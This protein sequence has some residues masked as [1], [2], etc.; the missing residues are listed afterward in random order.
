MADDKEVI[1]VADDCSTALTSNRQSLNADAAGVAAS[2]GQQV[3]SAHACILP[4]A[5]T[6]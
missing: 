4:M 6:R 2:Y 3:A 5:H 1:W